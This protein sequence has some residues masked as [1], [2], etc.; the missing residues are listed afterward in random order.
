MAV[1]NTNSTQVGYEASPVTIV[2]NCDSNCKTRKKVFN[3]VQ[4]AAAG[5]AGST[6]VLANLP[7]GRVRIYPLESRITWSAFGASR[8]LDVGYAAYTSEDGS[9]VTVSAAYFDDDID[10]SSA[11]TAAMGSDIPDKDKTKYFASK[12]GVSIY[13]TVAG[14]TIPAA[15]TIDGYITYTVE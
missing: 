15:A 11:G 2:K 12:S 14:G 6:A 13:A 10:V 8:L 4:G 5:D 7:A 3:F 9:A 1:T